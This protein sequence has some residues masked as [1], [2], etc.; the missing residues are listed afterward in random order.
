MRGTNVLTFSQAQKRDLALQD[1]AKRDEGVVTR[2]VAVAEAAENYLAWSREH[3]KSVTGTEHY[4]RVH[5]L[6][7]LGDR[8]VAIR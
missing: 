4:V 2:P 3:R 8:R 7:A 6:P 5:I 1:N